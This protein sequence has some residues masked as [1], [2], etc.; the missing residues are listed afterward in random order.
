MK[1][2]V[3]GCS[4]PLPKPSQPCSGYLIADEGVTVL[5]DCGSGVFA[6]LAERVDPA[7]LSAVWISHMHPDHSADLIALANWALNTSGAP[8]LR[9]I[10]PPGWDARLNGF[11]SGDTAHDV[12]REVFTVEHIDDGQV[13]R[14][15][16]LSLTTALVHHSVPTYGVRIAAPDATFAYSGDTGPCSALDRLADGADVFLCE[17]GANTPSEYHL[18]VPQ[19]QDI[20]R[21]ATVGTLLLTHL[22]EQTSARPPSSVDGP[23]IEIVSAGSEWDV[24]TRVGS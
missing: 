19:A 13:K 24:P 11:M 10:G 2:T 21:A 23:R 6:A 1:L 12:A 8:K 3:L 18:T 14:I 15:G 17:A 9:V 20:A 5:L 7:E 4:T 22:H 16:T